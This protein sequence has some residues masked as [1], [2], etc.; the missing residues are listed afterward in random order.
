[1]LI[2]KT[3][4]ELKELREKANAFYRKIRSIIPPQGWDCKIFVGGCVERGVGSSF[5]HS[6]HAHNSKQSKNFGQ[7]CFRS[8]KRLGKYTVT[9]NS[10]GT[11]DIMITEPGELL[12]HEYAHLLAPNQGHNK[13]WLNRLRELGGRTKKYER[14]YKS[15]K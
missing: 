2:P 6:A 13:T 9:D 8:I 7:L 11:V 10:G 5:R 4:Q 15:C 1:M 14:Q 3:P 12:K